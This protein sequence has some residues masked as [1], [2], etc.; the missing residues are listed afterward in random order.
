MM[1]HKEQE[2]PFTSTKKALD[3]FQTSSNDET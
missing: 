3:S 1:K 2:K